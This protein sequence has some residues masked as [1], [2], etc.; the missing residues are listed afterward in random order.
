MGTIAKQSIKGTIVTYL[1]VAI[2]FVTT[3]FVL[4]RFLTSEEIGLARV[5]VDAATLFIGLAQLGTSSSIIRFFPYFKDNSALCIEHSAP[6]K[7]YHGFFVYAMIV[8][9][10]G[11]AI[12]ALIYIACH[13]PLSV[14][15]GDKSPL[16]VN[17]Y[18]LVLPIAFFMLYQ[19]VL[20][21]C[22]TVLMHIVLP[23]FVREVVVRLCLLLTYLLY[24]FDVLSMDGFVWAICASYAI[25]SLINA[26]YLI[27][28][29]HPSPLTPHPLA[30]SPSNHFAFLKS[31]PNL[32]RSW[33]LYTAFLIVSAVTSVLAPTL[34][35][36]FIT[37]QMGLSYTGI[38]A[39]ATYMAVMVSV[40]SRSLVA[41]TQPELSLAI[42]NSDSPNI[43]RLLNQAS[44]NLLLAGGFILLVIWINIDLI[45]TILP[46]GATYAVAKPVVLLL[47]IGQ[48]MVTM[49]AI[50]APALSYSRFYAFSLLNSF[51]LTVT[52]LLLNNYLI[53]RYGMLGAAWATVLADVCYY[54]MM[55]LVVSL[56]LHV[57]PFSRRHLQILVLILIVFALNF[58]LT[59]IVHCAFCI[60]HYLIA[61]I[62]LLVAGYVAYK[63]D[64]SPELN[65]LLRQIRI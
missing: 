18:Y 65:A 20:E 14:F 22:S 2:G 45:F 32:V 57:S 6:E 47:G 46:N 4:T 43:Q 39:I 54:F 36:F 34:S 28:L 40:P 59:N 50:Y 3:F 63:F 60:L 27:H 51:V 42:K 35:S 31:N 58:V 13:N 29:L 26:G 55:T 16:F 24:A 8:P 33:I 15:F 19:T 9:L 41:I 5:L 52:A 38:F 64:L 37:A 49:F 62:I 48:L 44:A 25:A 7:S 21:T 12:F 56:T 53:P 1:G 61:N 10:I 11:F 23:K 17:Y 30:F